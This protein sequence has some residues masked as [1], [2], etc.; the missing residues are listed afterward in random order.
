MADADAVDDCVADAMAVLAE[1]PLD[2]VQDA[3]DVLL[4][5]PM[6]KKQSLAKARYVKLQKAKRVVQRHVKPLLAAHNAAAVR[7]KEQIDVDEGKP[8]TEK[9]ATFKKWLPGAVANACFP[10]RRKQ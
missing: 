10:E 5:A 9:R 4:N 7:V 8:L 3:L 2:A 1:G 6:N